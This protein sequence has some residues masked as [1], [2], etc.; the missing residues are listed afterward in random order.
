MVPS[1][2]PALAQ[3][4]VQTDG[5]HD[6]DV[7]NGADPADRGV[8]IRQPRRHHRADQSRRQD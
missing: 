5:Y 1:G 3:I 4:Y 7:V 6:V 8:R 2:S